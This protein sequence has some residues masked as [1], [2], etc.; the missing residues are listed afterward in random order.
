[1]IIQF[2]IKLSFCLFL[3]LFPQKGQAQ[4]FLEYQDSA[5][6]D[7][8]F[9]HTGF[10]GG[11]AA[12]FDYDND[13]DDDLYITAGNERDHF[14]ENNGDGTFLY[15]SIDAGFLITKLYYTT[16]V[17][18]GD[19]DNDGFKDL[20]IT[21]WFSDF[22]PTGRNLLYKNNGDGTF[23]E[24]WNHK[25]EKDNTQCMGA[26]FIDYDLDGLLDIY[27]VSYVDEAAFLYDDN[28]IIVGFD[29]TCFENRFY[30]NLGN[31]EFEEISSEINLN[32]TGCAL[33]VTA[34]DFDADGDLD[35][36]LAND[37]GEFIQP[38]KLFRNNIDE[39]NFTEVGGNYN[40]NIGLY[41]MGI[42]V[43]DIDNDLDLDY[44]VTN[45]GRNV[46]LKNDGVNFS[47][48]TDQSGV[49]DEWIIQDSLFAV[50]WGTALLDIDND[51]DLDLYVGNGFVPGPSFLSTYIFQ[52][53]KLFINNGNLEFSDVSTEYGI[54]NKY[55]T[56]GV[57]Y[58]DYDNDGD[59]DLLAVV[60]NVPVNG[61]YD[62]ATILYNNQNGNLRN[63]LQVT[64]EGTEVN[65]DAYGSKIYLHAG[66]K[67]LLTEI[68][69]GGSHASHVS[70]RAHFGLGEIGQVDSL[71]IVWTGGK[72]RQTLY[73]IEANQHIYVKE[74]TT[75]TTSV[76]LTEKE[77]FSF[78]YHLA[79]NPSNGQFTLQLFNLLD[80]NQV[81]IAI[82]NTIGQLIKKIKTKPDQANIPIN[83]DRINSG[84]Y[85]ISLKINEDIFI[86]KIIIER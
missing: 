17:I 46:L 71:Q 3:I 38:N 60:E 47:D 59:L 5:K 28:G 72:R 29:H 30:H 58:S 75:S 65:R 37:F 1:M 44:Y 31:S 77:N 61:G 81:E 10:L 20:F 15:K 78:Q 22:E 64:L 45:F 79:P 41:G 70:S 42:A 19:I 85:F 53:D 26:T 9:K 66:D 11:G 14:Y 86:D 35:I 52:N 8:I 67:T 32:D 25:E 73:D 36:Y 48:I 68:S 13:G 39:L 40:A 7:H 57:S 21:T 33:A 24:I 76:N 12:F 27:T 43:G 56:R 80:L 23:T 63:W 2:S 62:W 49:G 54:E 83:L 84:I 69:G 82:Y 50:G 51:S 74:D 16:G 55:T 34:T 4:F 6:I 18:A